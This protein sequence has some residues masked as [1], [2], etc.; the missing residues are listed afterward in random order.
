MFQTL[1]LTIVLVLSFSA[2]A[3]TTNVPKSM[4]K[5]VER[6]TNVIKSHDTK[7]ERLTSLATLREVLTL[8]HTRNLGRN[9]KAYNAR[10]FY[11]ILK[12]VLNIKKMSDCEDTKHQLLYVDNGPNKPDEAQEVLP[13]TQYAL[14][15]LEAV[16]N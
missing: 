1:F 3:Q 16:C 2:Q 14:D 10:Y 8:S 7:K 9:K 15:L 5:T 4:A 11:F 6:A 13:E 12:P